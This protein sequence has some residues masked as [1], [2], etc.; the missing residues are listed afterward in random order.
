VVPAFTPVFLNLCLIG[1]AIW[2]APLMNEPVMALAWGVFAAGIVQLLFQFPAL[3]R[4]GLLPR[5]RFGF[6]DSGVKKIMSLMLPALFGASVTQIN[7]LLDTVIAS[8]LATGS[9]SWLYYSDRLVEFPLGVFGVALATVILPRLSKNYATRDDKSF[10]NALDWGL[11][12]VVIIGV[13]ASI[14]LG[15]F[16]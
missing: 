2:L 5:L 11:R 8:F 14:G 15:A 12:W 1:A 6:K 7:L 10:S 3:M 9:I 4:L 16:G 13:P